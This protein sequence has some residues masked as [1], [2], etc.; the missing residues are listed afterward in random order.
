MSDVNK[1]ILTG[2]I[3][4]HVSVLGKDSRQ[5][6]ETFIMYAVFHNLDS[7][8]DFLRSLI[9]CRNDSSSENINK[10][11]PLDEI[12]DELEKLIASTQATANSNDLSSGSVDS[13]RSLSSRY[14]S[15]SI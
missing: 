10:A 6:Q 13:N 15:R 3:Y 4:S 9:I 2:E 5:E 1:K 14:I 8:S 12:E 7:L 11:N